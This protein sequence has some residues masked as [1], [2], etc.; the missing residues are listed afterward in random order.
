MMPG[1]S[2]WRQI[3]SSVLL[4]KQIVDY[5]FYPLK[6]SQLEEGSKFTSH[7]NVKQNKILINK[8][9]QRTVLHV[10]QSP[11]SEVRIL[12]FKTQSCSS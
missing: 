4:D 8:S 1:S 7:S 2:D 6:A 5:C 12:E 11:A 3:S 10:D 9:T